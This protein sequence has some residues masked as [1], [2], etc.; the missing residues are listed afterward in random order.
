MAS[1]SAPPFSEVSGDDAI[2]N[3]IFSPGGPG[4][5][6]AAP[7]Q[8]PLRDHTAPDADAV[9]EADAVRLAEAGQLDEALATLNELCA[10][11]PTRAS[12]F[13]NRAQVFKLMG[14]PDLQ[15][16]DVDTAI[17]LARDWLSRNSDGVGPAHDRT[18]GAQRAVLQQAL[19]QRAVY[20]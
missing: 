11:A 1:G 14:R 20:F 17:A 3:F 19:S 12:A 9:R 13:N 18:A 16:S 2:L 8:S 15:K 4:A 5:I 7:P 6:F 10:S